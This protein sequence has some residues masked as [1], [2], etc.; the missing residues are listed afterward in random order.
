MKEVWPETAD[1]D[2]FRRLEGQGFDFSKYYWIDFNV[3]FD[4]WPPAHLALE[5]PHSSYRAARIEDV[6]EGEG[7]QREAAMIQAEAVTS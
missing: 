3:D 2:V 6:K 5:R 4:E 1:G 7:A